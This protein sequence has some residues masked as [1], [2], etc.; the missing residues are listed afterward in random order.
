[1]AHMQI[2]Y[3]LHSHSTASDGTLTPTELVRKARQQGVDVLALTDHDTTA[4]LEE[5]RMVAAQVGL[6]LVNGVEISV[7]W[8]RRT[9]HIVGLNV[10]PQHEPLRQGLARLR[11]FRDWRAAEI[12]RRLEKAN[13]PDALAGA[14]RY[15]SGS[16]ISRTHFAHYLVEIGRSKSVR[17]VFKRFLVKDKPGHVPGQWAQLA[18][19]VGWI[20]DAGGQAVIA[21]PAR[22]GLTAT[23]L[24]KLM[25]E[26]AHAGGEAME[27]VTGS[28]SPDECLNMAA[29]VR[30][31]GLFASCGSDYHGPENPWIELG[32][33]PTLPPDCVPI[34]SSDGW[35]AP[36]AAA[37]VGS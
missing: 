18:E 2:Q 16:I 37:A 22:Y 36:V 12:G 3:D 17:E 32:K 11:A 34:W 15:A 23:K 21:H 8:E 33:L 9:V 30:R 13:I 25:D 6:T 4:G 7:T 31:Q 20:V 24:R 10:D 1:M 14:S 5:A 28:H 29:H 27:V 35:R 26:F 19:A